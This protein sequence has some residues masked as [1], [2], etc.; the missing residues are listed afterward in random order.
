VFLAR[1][2]KKIIPCKAINSLVCQQERGYGSNGCVAYLMS[3]DGCRPMLNNLPITEDPDH[4]MNRVS[5]E[6]EHFLM[7]AAIHEVAFEDRDDKEKTW[8]HQPTTTGT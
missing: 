5:R 4:H 8:K 6:D 2:H 1:P 7:Y 3:N